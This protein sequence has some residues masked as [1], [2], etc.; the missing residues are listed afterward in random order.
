[1]VRATRRLAGVAELA[2]MTR[3]LS[4]GW[5]VPSLCADRRARVW[6]AGPVRVAEM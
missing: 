1:M 2:W 5:P 3:P 4:T 6:C